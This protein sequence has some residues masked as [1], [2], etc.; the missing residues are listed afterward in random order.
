[1]RLWRPGLGL[2]VRAVE[3]SRRISRWWRQ[4]PR[5]PL[6]VRTATRLHIG[7]G[8]EILADWFNID[9]VQYPGI[10]L[11]HDVREGLPF[12]GVQYIFAEHLI[13]HLTYDEGLRF[14]KECR[15]ALS[16][17]GILR[18]STPN[19]DWVVQTQYDVSP[20]STAGDRID[21]CF[22]M[23]KAFRGWGHQ[24]LYNSA[25]LA[26]TVTAAGFKD[27]CFQRYRCSDDI[28][29]ANLERHEIYPDADELPHV[30]IIEASGRA[31]GSLLSVEPALNDYDNA[32]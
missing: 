13:E 7:C 27:V 29:L 5:R 25:T 1:M 26:E 16:E 6:R 17:T 19:L 22:A 24:F 8:P 23:N 12:R 18:L 10:D 32:L 14:L 3:M 20:A 9:R 15:A 2:H 31:A 28:V 21:A 30:I 11:V 4:R